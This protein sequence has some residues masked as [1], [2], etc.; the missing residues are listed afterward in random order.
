MPLASALL[1]FSKRMLKSTTAT[2]NF[3]LEGTNEVCLAAAK[4]KP[5]QG[6]VQA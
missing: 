3:F 1:G 5:Y 6:R 4:S 2:Q